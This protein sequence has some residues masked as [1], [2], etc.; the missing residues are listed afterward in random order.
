MP[1]MNRVDPFGTL[2]AVAARG[3]MMGN[4]GCLHDADGMIRRPFASKAWITCRL[5]WKD[6]AR[7]V[8]TP[9]RYSELFFL[10]EATAF[11]AG[12]RP[13]NFCRHQAYADFKA[14]WPGAIDEGRGLKAAEI[15]AQLHA[16]RIDAARAKRSFTARLASL[17]QG[18]M[19]TLPGNP[20]APRLLWGGRLWRWSFTGYSDPLAAAGAGEVTVL[21]P[22][23]VCEV[24]GRGYR[25]EADPGADGVVR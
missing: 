11:A 6:A 15:D 5:S 10:D 18:V 13:C 19:V 21:T 14:A 9:G 7:Q 24:L 4:R 20:A 12:H 17:P 22:R 1:R 2:H 16:E 3:A 23:S 8:F 25:V